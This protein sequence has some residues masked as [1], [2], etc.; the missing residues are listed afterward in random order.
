[1]SSSKLSSRLHENEA[2]AMRNVWAVLAAISMAVVLV[3]LLWFL[4]MQDGPSGRR[5]PF[6]WDGADRPHP[7]NVGHRIGD[8]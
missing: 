5:K 8:F 4:A 6:L 7:S 1:M 2:R 3:F